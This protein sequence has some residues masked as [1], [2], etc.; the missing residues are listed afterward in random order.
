MTKGWRANGEVPG[1]FG[2]RNMSLTV[3][4]T[5]QIGKVIHPGQKFAEDLFLYNSNLIT[6]DL[7]TEFSGECGQIVEDIPFSD[8]E[9]YKE[10]IVDANK[11][12]IGRISKGLNVFVL[13]FFL[14]LRIFQWQKSW[15]ASIPVYV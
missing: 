9:H 11:S 3:I 7:V 5:L 14:I 13:H 10:E 4:P 12:S 1:E 8:S 2:T 6:W 15:K